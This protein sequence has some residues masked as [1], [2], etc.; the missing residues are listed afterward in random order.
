M[1]IILILFV[2]FIVIPLVWIIGTYNRLVNL[3]NTLTES[4][5]DV[6]TELQ[7]RYDLIPNLVETVKG[8]AAHERAVFEEVARARSAAVASKGT[9]ESQ[10]ADENT[11]VRALGGLF[12]VAESYPQLKASENFLHLQQELVN[13]EDRIQAARRFYNGNVRSLNNMVQMFPS[14]LIASA[15]SFSPGEYFEIE[16]VSMRQ[17]VSVR[18]LG[19]T[20]V[21]PRVSSLRTPRDGR[22]NAGA[23][24][25]APLQKKKI[26]DHKHYERAFESWLRQ[27]RVP[28]VAIEQVRRS[29][30]REGPIK[31]FD[32]LVHSGRK[33][34]VV[35]VK[36]K[37][38][39]AV[40]GTRET[41]WENWIHLDDIEGL[42][43]WEQHFGAS[44]EA[45]L[46]Y[47]Y[48]L[49]LPPGDGK[50]GTVPLKAQGGQ[51]PFSFDGRDYL[52]VAVPAR[53]FAE[54]CR[55]RS[56]RWKAVH[57]PE[58]VFTGLIRPVEAFFPGSPADREP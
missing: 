46:V 3:R 58:K 28:Y 57:V 13:T 34:W 22:R 37:R 50:K 12:A 27:R 44:Y 10:A 51:S 15:G 7:R 55:K 26:M 5:R 20:C 24:I 14:S 52:L 53:T 23:H 49:Q 45:L 11:L 32:F 4:W 35:D 25:G 43:A 19:G 2:V 56:A 41:W 48:W 17:P 38:F 1:I 18:L 16:S 54:H 6:D 29:A 8:Y 33:H 9:P 30:D 36:G 21:S 40:S 47:C 31:S 39:P 42:F